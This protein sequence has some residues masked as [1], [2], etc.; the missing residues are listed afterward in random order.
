MVEQIQIMHDQSLKFNI[1]RSEEQVT[2][3]ARRKALE[4]EKNKVDLPLA[5][6]KRR[7]DLERSRVQRSRSEERLKKLLADR[8]LMTVKS[9]ADGIVYYGK[10]A[11]GKFSDSTVLAES[12]R[13]HGSIQANQVV[14]TVV[15]PRPVFVRAAAPEDQLHHLRPGLK[16]TAAPAAYP[17]QKLAVTIDRV[18]DVPISPGSFDMRLKVA[19]DKRAKWL[20]P[21][22]NCKVK[23]VAYLKKEAITVPPKTVVPDELDDQKHFVYVLEKEGKPEKRAVTLGEKTD[24]QVEILKGLAEGDKVLL[25]APKEQ[26]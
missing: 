14:M 9:P 8:E 18:S 23:I 26:K 6:Q 3:A 11:R 22:M 12:L 17:N 21:G 20:M 19:L 5:L 25:E 16:G 4:W 10:C 1:P 24:K 15:E 7:L 13:R 2:E